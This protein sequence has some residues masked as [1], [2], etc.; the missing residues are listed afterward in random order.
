MSHVRGIDTGAEDG[1]TSFSEDASIN[2]Y[3]GGIFEGGCLL[4]GRMLVS[5]GQFN[6]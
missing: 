3:E 2:I 1:A 4:L 5:H 6:C